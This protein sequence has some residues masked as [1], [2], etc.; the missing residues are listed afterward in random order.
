MRIPE[1]LLPQGWLL[2]ADSA[3]AA[4]VIAA[5]Y[6]APWQRLRQ[7]NLLNAYLGAG[8]AL[9]VLWR[10][11]AAFA[12]RP[13][14]HFLGVTTVTLMFGWELAVLSA[15]LALLGIAI[16]IAGGWQT[17]AVNALATGALPAAISYA[18]YRIID[19]THFAQP[20]LRL[21]LS[22]SVRG[23]RCRYGVEQFRSCRRHD[24]RGNLSRRVHRSRI[25]AR[26][27]AHEPTRGRAQRHGH[28]TSGFLPTTI[29]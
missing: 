24:R 11:S 25:F 6:L 1:G 2:L 9:M 7:K 27:T 10:I 13:G 17:F 19:R 20:Y 28:D 23:R 12:D 8:V 21:H 18:A 16:S 29:G 15:G 22:G 3:Y 5:L 14:I 4:V 26:R